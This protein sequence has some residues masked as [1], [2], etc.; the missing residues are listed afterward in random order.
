MFIEES[1]LLTA[2]TSRGFPERVARDYDSP[3]EQRCNGNCAYVR[4]SAVCRCYETS[5]QLFAKIRFAR[6]EKLLFLLYN[7]LVL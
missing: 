1:L 2:K 4:F 7:F 6:A 3:T 5:V